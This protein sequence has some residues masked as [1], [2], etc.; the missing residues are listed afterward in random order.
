MNVLKKPRKKRPLT[1]LPTQQL[2]QQVW[3]Y[4]LARPK[5]KGEQKKELLE[6][7]FLLCWKVGLRVSEAIAFNLSLVHPEPEYKNL[8]LLRGKGSKD[9]WVYLSEEIRQE[10]KKRNW[11]PH[12]VHRVSF[13]DFLNQL[14]KELRIP[15]RTE[16][17]PHTLRRCF[18]T[19]TYSEWQ[20]AIQRL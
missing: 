12:R 7:V 11:K 14:K 18:A 10:L 13:F 9:R 1:I 8:Y 2:V 5:K 20:L 17:A 4:V 3:D 6:C 19:S 15:A 16:L